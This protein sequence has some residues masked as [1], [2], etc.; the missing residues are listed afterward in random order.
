MSSISTRFAG[1]AIAA[2]LAT[3]AATLAATGAPL[4]AGQAVRYTAASISVAAPILAP[5]R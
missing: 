4:H 1:L 5:S 3:T 2:A